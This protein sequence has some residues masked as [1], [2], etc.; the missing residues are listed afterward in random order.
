MGMSNYRGEYPSGRPVFRPVKAEPFD[1]YEQ[2]TDDERLEALWDRVEGA[3][4]IGDQSHA[5]AV[6]S[7]V[8]DHEAL[9]GLGARVGRH[10]PRVMEVASV[11]ALVALGWQRS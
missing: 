10:A 2:M 4:E 6:A 8:R 3:K 7:S 5:R 1:G 9:K 11:L